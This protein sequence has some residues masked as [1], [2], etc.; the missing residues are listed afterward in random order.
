MSA[1]PARRARHVRV[2]TGILA[3]TEHHM[4]R[5]RD[6]GIT[7]DMPRS[8]AQSDFVVTAPPREEASPAAPIDG[9][10][11][12]VDL[13]RAQL[14]S[15]EASARATRLVM[16]FTFIVLSVLALLTMIGPHIPAGE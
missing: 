10:T 7:I 16:G 11:G 6:P 9:A 8:A 12:P 4:T 2:P 3:A 15:T 5:G 13:P 1:G 14:R